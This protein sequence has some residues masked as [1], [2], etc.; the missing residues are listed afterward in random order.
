MWEIVGEE[1]SVKKSEC[2]HSCWLVLPAARKRRERMCALSCWQVCP[3]RKACVE[4]GERMLPRLFIIARGSDPSRIAGNI[5]IGQKYEFGTK[6]VKIFLRQTIIW[7]SFCYNLNFSSF[8]YSSTPHWSL[9]YHII[10]IFFPFLP[11]WVLH[12]GISRGHIISGL[13]CLFHNV[14]YW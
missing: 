3:T 8:F 6:T 10:S 12:K 1:E 7:N 14:V 5:L 9:M 13:L 11:P 2:G 4:E